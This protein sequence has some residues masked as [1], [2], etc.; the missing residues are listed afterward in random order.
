MKTQAHKTN[1][2]SIKKMIAAILM[3]LFYAQMWG[4]DQPMF[5]EGTELYVVAN[6]GLTLRAEANT[7]SESLGIIEFGSSVIV[8]P[9]EDVA[10]YQ[11]INWVE[12]HWIFVDH[13]G[14]TGY[15]FDGFLSDLPLPIYDFEKCHIDTDLLYPLESWSEINLG[16]DKSDTITA[17]TLRRVTDTFESGDKMIK[18]HKNDEYKIE[19]YLTDVR[20]MDVYHLL[21]S[22]L[23]GKS[24]IELYKEEST[25]IENKEG[26]L[27][28]IMVDLD[29]PVWIRKLS[30]GEVKVTIK[31]MNDVCGL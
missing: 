31:T 19:L 14:V 25:F 11:K 28:K 9:Q 20:I 21:Q 10:Q 23:D 22:M 15:M 3:V 26:D 5:S 4:A 29:N 18:T 13:E 30:S 24:S 16:L 7:Q 2:S 8:L 1:P 12:G 6:S 17:G 27:Y